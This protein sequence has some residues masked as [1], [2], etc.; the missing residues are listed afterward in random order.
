MKRPSLL[1]SVLALSLAVSAPAALAYV[2]H[3]DEF[4]A[5][6]GVDRVEV[7]AETDPLLGIQAAPI[8]AAADGS[9]AVMIPVGAL[10]EDGDRERRGQQNPA[11]ARVPSL[12]ADLE[13]RKA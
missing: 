8:E 5:E 12:G 7:N 1:S 6:E 10:V 13:R 9:G 4:Q 2:G 11:I 3:G